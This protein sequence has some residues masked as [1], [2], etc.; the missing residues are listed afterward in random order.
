MFIVDDLVLSPFKG[1]MWLVRELHSAAEREFADERERTLR[2]LQSLHMRLE[3]GQI[4]E[5]EF[6]AE[7][8]RL[9]DR[10]DELDG[11]L[12]EDEEEEEAGADAPAEAQASP[13]ERTA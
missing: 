12:G 10:L 5:D 3:A 13:G 11:V 1:F 9:L 2:A 6:D 4:D 8:A 7:E